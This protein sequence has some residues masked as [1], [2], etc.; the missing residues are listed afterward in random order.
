MSVKRSG[1]NAPLAN[2]VPGSV[3]P[4][5]SLAGMTAKA[6]VFSSSSGMNQPLSNIA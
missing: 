3:P 6:A 1:M 4:D 2:M 5:M